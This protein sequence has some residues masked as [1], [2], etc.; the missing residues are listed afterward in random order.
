M[1]LFRTE[2]LFLHPPARAQPRYGGRGGRLPRYGRIAAR[3]AHREAARER[4]P[5]A[6]AAASCPAPAPAFARMRAA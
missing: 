1:H 2:M 3:D 6:D 4:M 5:I